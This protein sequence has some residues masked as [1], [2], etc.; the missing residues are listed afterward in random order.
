MNPKILLNTLNKN[1]DNSEIPVW[2][3]RQAG[4]YLPEYRAIRQKFPSFLDLCYNPETA[5]EIT[6]QPVKRF[7]F[8]AAILFSDILV[9][10]DALGLNLKFIEGEGPLLEQVLSEETFSKL[11][12]NNEKLLKVYET[13]KITK[14]KLDKNK[15]LI[16][17]AGAPWTIA[18]YMIEG[19]YKKGLPNVKKIL[20]EKP[21]LF[22]KITDLLV[23]SITEHLICQIEAGV[24]VL[25]IFDSWAGEVS[26]YLYE[27]VIINPTKR[28]VSRVKEKYKDIPIIGFPRNSGLKLKE[29][30][31]KSGVDA[32]S[33]DESTPIKW[34]SENIQLPIQGNLDPYILAFSKDTAIS[35]C[36]KILES[37]KNKKF[38]F[39]LGHGVIPSTPLENVESVVKFVKSYRR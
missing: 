38:I 34:A 12:Y 31:E 25:Q 5:S 35:H 20:L 30:S 22:F 21:E 26:E 11:K 8:D 6:I 3:M 23:D 10:P 2:F 1:S 14:S 9:I 17:F 19:R 15:T 39:N 32:V 18:V 27:D 28:I 13:V 29:Y 36:K 37:T 24:D 33:I 7:D 16:G 4:R